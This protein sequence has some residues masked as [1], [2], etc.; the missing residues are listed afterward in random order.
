ML[1]DDVSNVK[2]CLTKKNNIY[3]SSIYNEQEKNE[4]YKPQ[5]IKN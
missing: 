1:L 2:Y 3:S 5:L 4:I